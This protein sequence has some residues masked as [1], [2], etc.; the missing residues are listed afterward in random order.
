MNI[1]LVHPHDIFDKSEPW[2]VR[3]LSLAEEFARNNHSVKLCYFPALLGNQK[4]ARKIASI[5]LIPLNRTPS[6]FVFLKNCRLITTMGQWADIIHFQKCHY[7][8]SLPAVIAAYLK[9]KPLHYDWDD[10]EEQIWYESCGRGLHSTF[11]GL[12]FK[13]L[14]R[15]LPVL[16]D[17]VSCASE[18]LKELTRKLGV[19]DEFIFEAPVGADLEKFHSGISGAHVKQAY[20]IEEN[21]ELVLYIGQLHG[22]QYVDLFIRAAELVLNK[23]QNVKFMIVGDGFLKSS[24]RQ[25]VYDLELQNKVI[26]TGAVEH[27]TI[28]SYIAA[29]SI[30]VAPFRDTAVTRC[31]SP[32]KIVEYMASGKAIVASNVG[33]AR[34]MLSGAGILT[35]PGDHKALAEGMSRLL[36]DKDL[37][38]KLGA[39]ARKKAVEQFN[40]QSTASKIMCAYQKI[41]QR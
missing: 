4:P 30:C 34:K 10:W 16:S 21:E 41:S 3:I 8:A 9:N 35:K 13:L 33:E 29:S 2:T 25:L 6:P 12:S 15:I 26:F 39:E 20:R 36:T 7:Y 32:L 27:D 5:D 40:W 24:L 22:A 31:K 23:Q 18:H 11:I 38:E 14:E 28:P 37:R 1:L 19:D 17:S